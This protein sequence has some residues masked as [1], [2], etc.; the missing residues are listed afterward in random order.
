ME[1]KGVVFNDVESHEEN[2]LVK[3]SKIIQNITNFSNESSSSIGK[4]SD[5]SENLMEKSCDDDEEVQSSYNK[6]ALDAMDALEQVLPIR[7]GISSFYNGKSKSF[8]ILS[9]AS[10]SSSSIKAIAK[11]DN[12]YTRKRRN[13]LSCSLHWDK[14]RTSCLKTSNGIS[15]RPTGLTRTTTLALGLAMANPQSLKIYFDSKPS[16]FSPW[17]SFSLADLQQQ[18]ASVAKTC[19]NSTLNLN[20]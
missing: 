2:G 14:T 6:G 8:T 7:R 4:N 18:C 11:P 5:L 16:E 10:S 3:N 15:K 20:S 12:A 19:S 13:Q 9:D 17:K 1:K